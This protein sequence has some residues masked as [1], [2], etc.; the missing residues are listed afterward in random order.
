MKINNQLLVIQ[1]VIFAQLNW[2]SR[3]CQSVR[4]VYDRWALDRGDS[5]KK[6]IQNRYLNISVQTIYVKHEKLAY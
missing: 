5:Q 4:T 1:T 3:I 6:Y 2:K